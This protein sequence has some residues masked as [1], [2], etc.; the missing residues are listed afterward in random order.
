M[1]TDMNRAQ[2]VAWAPGAAEGTGQRVL[3]AVPSFPEPMVPAPLSRGARIGG[4]RTSVMGILNVTPDSFSDGGLWFDAPRAIARGLQLADEGALIVDVGGESTRPGARRITA[5]EEWER[6]ASVVTRLVADG[7]TVSIDTV[8]AEVARRAVAEGASLINDVSGGCHDSEILAVAAREGVSMVI[9]HWR[10]FPSDPHLNHYYDDVVDGVK[11]EIEAQVRTALE[12][13]VD[14]ASVIVDPGLGFA[15]G[16]DDSWR[17]L[18]DLDTLVSLGFP[19]LVGA[20]RKRFVS[21]RFPSDV[22]GGTQATTEA[23]VRA[24]AWAVRVHDVRANVR[25][26]EEVTLEQKGRGQAT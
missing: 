1:A 3:S 2:D 15:K 18:E 19:V 10:G 16:T 14:Q 26:V 22:E 24:G 8:N 17:L 13:G 4:E 7:V 20:S 21:A 6:V 23:A 25:I 9:Q 5:E 12:C 11:A